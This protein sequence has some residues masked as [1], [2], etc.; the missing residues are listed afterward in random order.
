MS[1]QI[2]ENKIILREILKQQLNKYLTLIRI[3]RCLKNG[4]I[5]KALPRKYIN[6]MYKREVVHFCNSCT[7]RYKLYS[8]PL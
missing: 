1:I 8:D 2:D 7:S 6:L 3:N 5:L 4:S